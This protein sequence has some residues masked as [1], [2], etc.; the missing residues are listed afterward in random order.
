MRHTKRHVKSKRYKRK[1]RRTRRG[2]ANAQAAAPAIVD[3]FGEY[4]LAIA[5]MNKI[6]NRPTND[7]VSEE[8]IA[9]ATKVVTDASISIESSVIAI[10]NEPE[11]A[12]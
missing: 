10:T 3:K 12:P 4:K 6:I 1:G 5:K 2:G 8:L 11:P 7:A 9:T